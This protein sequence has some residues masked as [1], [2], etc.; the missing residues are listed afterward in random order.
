MSAVEAAG[1]ALAGVALAFALLWLRARRAD[2]RARARLSTA[3]VELERLEHAFARFAP[4]ELVERVIARGVPT[5]GE[6]KEVT[7]LFADLVGFTP[8]SQSVEPSTLVRILNGYFERMSRAITAH[9]GHISTLIGDGILALFGALEANPWQTNDAVQAAL[10]MR[11]EL[12]AYNEELAA[13]GLP[14]LALGVGVHRGWGIAGLV[15]SSELMQFTVVG[16]VVSVAARVQGL[17]REHGVD[18]LV[19]AAAQQ[20]LDPRFVLRALPPAE[21]KGIAEPVSTFALL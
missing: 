10:G 15:G 16:N 6:R 20:A 19:T 5:S 9:Q 4:M 18:V 8:L 7:V 2:A 21:L 11:A 17:T 12:A 13:S 3:T 14:K 1:I